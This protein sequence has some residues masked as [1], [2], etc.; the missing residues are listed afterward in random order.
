M[1]LNHSPSLVTSGLVLALDAANQKS[2]PGSGTTWN[3]LSGLGNTGTLGSQTYNSA[4][5]TLT[6]TG[7]QRVDTTT[8]F[9]IIEGTFL[10][11]IKRNGTQTDYTGILFSRA[12][13]AT[14]MDFTTS[15][16]LGYHWNDTFSTYGW[17]SGLIIPDS[18]WCMVA[19]TVNSTTGTAYLC[20]SSGITTAVNAVSHSLVSVFKLTVGQDT[21]SSLRCF[22]GDIGPVMFYNRALTSNE[23]TQNFNA[24]RG[25]FG[26]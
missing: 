21:A 12:G 2:Y 6:F 26:I 20:Q 23:I 10:A 16:N 4:N 24:Q 25:R 17:I 1:G 18:T 15:Q 14:G 5:G 9:T 8:T 13:A 11:W 7:T 3:D 22:I 19:I